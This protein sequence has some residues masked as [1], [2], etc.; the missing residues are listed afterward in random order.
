MALVSYITAQNANAEVKKTYDQKL[1]GK[2][3]NIM[4]A[5]AHRPEV[6]D[7]FLSFYAS[8]GKAIDKRL[9]ELIYIRVSTINN[10]NYCLH[11]HMASSKRSGL[12]QE[13]WQALKN[14]ESSSKFSDKEK[15]ALRY[16]EKITRGPTNSASSE[17]DALKKHFSEEQIVDIVSEVALVNLTNRITD[18]LALEIEEEV[19]AQVA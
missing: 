10:C 4:M 5:M 8:I 12:T 7:T 19:R 1:K 17:A 3:G 15:A 9:Y 11:H 14:P 13:D 18:G 16:A 6:L 2:P